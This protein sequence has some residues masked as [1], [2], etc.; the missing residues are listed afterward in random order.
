MDRSID[1]V[2]GRLGAF[3]VF[4]KPFALDDLVS[5]VFEAAKSSRR[6]SRAPRR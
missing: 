4:H 6:T 2:A 3:R 1:L 5:G